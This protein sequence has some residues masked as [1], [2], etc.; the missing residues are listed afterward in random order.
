LRQLA[1]VR[2]ELDRLRELA[3]DAAPAL[4][5]VAD[6]DGACVW[7]NQTWLA[8]RG[9]SMDDELGDGWGDG[10]HPGDLERCLTTYRAAVAAREPF[11]MEYRMLR[12]DGEYRL[13]LDRGE[14]VR[15]DGTWIGFCGACIDITDR[16]E[17]EQER[18]AYEGRFRSLAETT[19]TFVFSIDPEG[20]A[21]EPQPGWERYT[22]QRWPEYEG[23]GFLDVIHP[24]D[25]AAV[26]ATRPVLEGGA[27]YRT[28]L[29]VRHGPSRSWR[30]CEIRAAPL[31]EH[32]G[33][34]SEWIGTLTDIEERWRTEQALAESE[35]RLASLVQADVIGIIIGEGDRIEEANDAF[36]DMLGLDRAALERGDLHWT[37][38][39]PRD[40]LVESRVF[41]EELLREGRLPPFEKD[42]LHRDG[43]R[44]PVLLG[45]AR[46]TV[47]PFRW[48]CAVTDLTGRREAERTAVEA[49]A[50]AEVS[51]R[52]LKVLLR[53][54][55]RLQANLDVDG[56][57]RAVAEEVVPV[58]ADAVTVHLQ[59]G[60]SLD[61]VAA[62]GFP[63]DSVSDGLRALDHEA[64]EEAFRS[65]RPHVVHS[66][67]RSGPHPALAAA[68]WGSVAAYPLMA[69]NRTI[70]AIRFLDRPQRRFD[71]AELSLAAEVA[72]RA[73]VAADHARLYDE[74]RRV[75]ET[76][77][78]SLLP[79]SLPDIPGIDSAVRYWAAAATSNVGGDFY[80]LFPT[81]DGAWGV[82]VGDV[83][84]KGV[85]AAALTGVARHTV[86]AAASHVS[87]TCDALHWLHEAI[88][89]QDV[90]TF[91]TAC[92]GIL[93][94]VSDGH[95]RLG[96]CL[97]GH[98]P[99][100]LVRADGTSEAVGTFGTVL[101]LIEE[102][103][104][105]ETTVELRTGDV[106]LLYTDGLTDAPGGRGYSI[107]QLGTEV[108][109]MA[110][111]AANAIA[112]HLGAQLALRFADGASDDTA[113]LV[114]KVTA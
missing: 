19:A 65:G 8:F 45:G 93:H 50:G 34:I 63:P 27:G 60:E 91:C 61:Q 7:F 24:D 41:A 81:G 11:E 13:V 35:A 29:R 100:V 103:E 102:V 25:R 20:R 72:V 51:N 75:A 43:H 82:L 52:R 80:D 87:D 99:L 40:Q 5:W 70:G 92:F 39:T 107:D 23:Y 71:D 21:V 67:G 66:L 59:R 73:A 111:L 38:L 109:S 56:A 98:P 104:L 62:S 54:G 106:L 31:R 28:L 101:G 105:A 26:S 57:L 76:L 9:R 108:A 74:Q 68:G 84:G 69:H 90:P 89:R 58:V 16:R 48:I 95:F 4:V 46:L 49:R 42:F 36:L 77:Q 97:G 53:V 113:L 10:V 86:R 114:L 88:S 112:D 55:D 78:R 32:D 47:E 79:S 1:E 18:V 83:C 33:S 2:T 12:H 94:Q 3:L 110:H 64:A 15:E 6:L 22:E 30:H 96:F 37:E 17:L 14:P 44:V 85:D